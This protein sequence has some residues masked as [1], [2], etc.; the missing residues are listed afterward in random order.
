MQ[1]PRIE[2]APPSLSQTQLS[3]RVEASAQ[4]SVLA[5]TLSFVVLYQE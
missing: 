5:A 3:L 4:Q 2:A 1:I